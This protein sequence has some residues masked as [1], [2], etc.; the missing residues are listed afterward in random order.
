MIE[1]LSRA[2]QAL[3][4]SGGSELDPD[5]QFIDLGGDSLSALS[6]SNLLQDIFGVE[7]P[8]GV[9]I[10]PAGSL[11]ELA[12]YV[13]QQL[14]SDAKRPTFA[15]VHG[16]DSVEVRAADLTLEKFIDAKTLADAR[17]LAHVTGEPHTVLLTGANGY[18]GRF[19]ALEWLQRLS[20]TGGELICI[21]RGSDDDAARTRLEEALAGGDD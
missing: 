18:L 13:E 2:A 7:V 12:K 6:F 5:A 14:G 17:T 19:L 16:A 21:V 15:S 4:G 3:L 11:R 9:I 1:T 10:G 20:E 8:V